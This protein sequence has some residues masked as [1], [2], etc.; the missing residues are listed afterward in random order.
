[1]GGLAVR[2]RVQLNLCAGRAGDPKLK[3]IAMGSWQ[4]AFCYLASNGEAGAG[5]VTSLGAA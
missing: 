2:S 1:M 3:R 5:A 4:I